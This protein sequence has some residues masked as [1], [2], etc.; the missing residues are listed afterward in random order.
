MNNFLFN[1][2]N[3]FFRKNQGIFLFFSV[4]TEKI[5]LYYIIAQHKEDHENRESFRDYRIGIMAT[6]KDV[7]QRAQVAPSTI[8]KYINGGHVRPEHAEAIQKAITEL[9]YRV[10]PYARGL[11]TQPPRSIGILT[12][13]M[14][15][16]FFG[17][18]LLAF[19]KVMRENG[20]HT[21]TSCYGSNHGLER[22][23]L[24]FLLSAG[25]D[26]LLYIPEDLSADEFHELTTNCVVPVV[27]VDRMIQGV[28]T[29]A[30]LVDNTGAV[31]DAVSRLIDHGHRRVAIITGPKS[32]L[33]AKERLVGYLRALSDHNYLYDDSLVISGPNAFATGYKGFLQLMALHTPPTAIFSTNYDITMGLITAARERGVRI[34][35]DISIFGFDC[36]EVCAM[37]NPPLPVVQQPEQRLGTL[38]ADY[39]LER[40][41]GSTQEPRQTRLACLLHEN[42]RKG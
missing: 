29:D 33:T 17:S 38:A 36:V 12:P 19:D 30:V 20:Y 23:N 27:Q 11:K 13:E 5:F 40:L 42:P 7:A 15:A 3:Q 9:G 25:I 14:N 6:I 28:E 10:N 22:D 41:E 8:S 1:H 4:D 35:E 2:Y 18:V 34:P 26:G 39:L 32:V 31:Y 21:L 16:P 37:L 24:R